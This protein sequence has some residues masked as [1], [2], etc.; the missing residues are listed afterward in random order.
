M[1][2]SNLP[3]SKGFGSI[4]TVRRHFPREISVLWEL[5]QNQSELLERTVNVIHC[6]LLRGGDGD[7]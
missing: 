3:I 5:P 1:N 7:D 2:I 4:C 6:F